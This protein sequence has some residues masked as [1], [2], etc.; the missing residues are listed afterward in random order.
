MDGAMGLET[1]EDYVNGTFLG[2][3][4]FFDKLLYRK[5]LIHYTLIS[6]Y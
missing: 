1:S 3:Y 2:V 6:F 4:I 5:L